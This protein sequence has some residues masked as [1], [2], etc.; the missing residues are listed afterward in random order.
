M[1]ALNAI[2]KS[3]GRTRAVDGLRLRLHPGE[4]F[5]LLGPNGAGKTTT[6]AMA[7]GLMEPDEGTVRYH[8]ASGAELGPP[9]RRSV[10]R[11]LGLCPQSGALYESM[12]GRENLEFLARLQGLSRGEAG[13]RSSAL[14]EAVGLEERGGDRVETY[15]GGMKRR[16]SLAGALVHDPGLVLLDEPTAGVDPQSRHA[17]FDLVQQ[18]R[19]AGRTVVY[20]THAM[21][22]AERLCDRVGVIDRGRLLALGTVDELVAAYGGRSVVTIEAVEGTRRIETDS[23][24]DELRG[25]KLGLGD[26][27]ADGVLGVRIERPSLETV[28]LNLTGRRLRD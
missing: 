16:L 10:R 5:G 20:T 25:L 27:G 26:G 4:V 11:M 12:T 15:S 18:Q 9:T 17:I 24:L 13:R 7:V 22:E 1:L 2:T 3:F 19:A 21:E 14:L 23:P 28:F 8:D 6:I